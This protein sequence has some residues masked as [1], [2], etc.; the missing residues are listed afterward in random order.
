M[1]TTP[2]APRALAW[3]PLGAVPPTGLVTARMQLHHAAQ[4]ANA[5][6]TS[7]LPPLPDDSH[8]SFGWDA[9]L[10]ALVARGLPAPRPLR[11]ALRVE[12]LTLLALA[13]GAVAEL[14]LDG[15]S[16]ADALAWVRAQASAAGADGARVT[17]RRHFTIPGEAPSA[18]RPWRAGSGAE[19]REL[20]AWYANAAAL[21][22]GVAAHEPGAGAVTCWPHHFDVA[23]LI[24][25]GR[26]A[27]GG[28]RTVGVGLSPG[29]E[30]YAEPYLY[31]GPY[32]HPRARPLPEL[33]LGRWHARGWFGAALTGSEIVSAGDTAAQERCARAFVGATLSAVRALLAR[34]DADP[35]LRR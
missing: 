12:D 35:S 8:T 29:D 1:T 28:R 11:F 27:R 26:D 17:M 3:R 21:L 20:A 7:L 25:E 34:E 5:A 2:L 31:V 4:V 32:P 30:H 16:Q 22:R 13:G 23:T 18:E 10:G 6:A 19:L 9:D 15:Q 33:P 14:P 24:E